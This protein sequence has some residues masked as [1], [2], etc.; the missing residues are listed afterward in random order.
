[1]KKIIIISLFIFINISHVNS[2]ALGETEITAEDGIEV[3]QK[4]KY[5]LLKKNVKIISDNL[6]LSADLVRA[7]FDKDLYDITNIYAEGS[8]V[9]NADDKG[10]KAKVNIIEFTINDENIKING[11]NSELILEEVSMFSNGT[12]DVNN[13]DGTFLLKGTKSKM[14]SGDINVYGEYIEGKFSNQNEII[15][16]NVEDKKLSNIKTNDTNMFAVRAIYDK[17]NNIIEL[18]EK[19]KV[20]RG[21]ETIT[22]DYGFVDIENN[23]YKVTSDNSKKVKVLI[24]Q[25]D[26]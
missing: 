23:S 15:N 6:N 26:E 7:Y 24:S 14:I 18:K 16:L 25:S 8:V 10:V 12:I 1:M 13:I 20:I 19:V 17:K 2:K 11:I 9:L 22:G 3:F 5:Y 4:E 21:N